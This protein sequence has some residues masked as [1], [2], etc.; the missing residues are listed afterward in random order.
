[1]SIILFPFKV[2]AVLFSGLGKGL[3]LFIAAVLNAFIVRWLLCVYAWNTG[4][5]HVTSNVILVGMIAGFVLTF[6]AG[7]KK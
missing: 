3:G 4:N 1:M 5:A 7:S 6:V 2:L